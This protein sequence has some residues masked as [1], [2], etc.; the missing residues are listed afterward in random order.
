MI[1]GFAITISVTSATFDEV[2]NQN[3]PDT[4]TVAYQSLGLPG[5]ESYTWD[6]VQSEVDGTSVNFWM[7]SG[8]PIIN[9]WVDDWLAPQ[10]K[11]Q[12]GII[13]NRVPQGA[14]A[15]VTQMVLEKED[16]NYTGGDVDLVWINGVNYDTARTNGVL[17]GPFATKIP[18]ALN[19]NFDSEDIKYDFGRTTNGYEMPYNL[20]QVA[21]I[22]N[23]DRFPTGPPQ[24]MDE[25]MSWVMGD[26]AGHFTYPNPTD[27]FTG[28][29]F[30]RHFLYYFPKSQAYEEMFG[31][32]DASVYNSRAPHTFNNLREIAPFLHQ[33]N[34]APHYPA[35]IGE[36][37]AL[38]ASGD[39]WLTLNYDQSHAGK[40]VEARIWPI[41]T[42]SYIPSSGTLSNTNFVAVGKYAN[43]V[44][45][46]V[47]V[48]N[49]IG[50]IAAQFSRAQ[51]EVWGALQAYGETIY[52]LNQLKDLID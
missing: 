20:A 10:C 19:F 21:F 26:G 29:A 37:D 1:I 51:P 44:L 25:L 18:S 27:D 43:N 28:S 23:K 8:N 33:M 4:V 6:D 16:G 24:T 40:Q 5:Y 34:G 46:G 39:I 11:E 31:S 49:V 22:Y 35:T 14:P 50:S 7:W 38:F 17:Y 2:K 42:Q 41:S 13:L 52:D 36:S 12:Y 15:A 47:A 48:A 9:A 45:G 30:I 32:F 3:Y